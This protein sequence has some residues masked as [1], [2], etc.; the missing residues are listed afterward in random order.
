[1]STVLAFASPGALLLTG[2]TNNQ[3]V[4]TTELSDMAGVCFVNG[5]RP[6]EDVIRLA[7]SKNIPLLASPCSLYEACGR[8][9]AQGIPDCLNKDKDSQP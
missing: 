7:E 1:M 8:L 9:Y 2:L 6:S 4:R 3:V 5:R